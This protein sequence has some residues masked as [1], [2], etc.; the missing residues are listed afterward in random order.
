L[1]IKYPLKGHEGFTGGLDVRNNG[2][3]IQ[4]VY[5]KYASLEIMFHVSTL[6]PHSEVDNQQVEIKRHIG[7]DIVVIIFSETSQ[8][9]SPS[10]ITSEFNHVY[11]VIQP[12]ETQSTPEATYYRIGFASK[13]GVPPFGPI[14]P[15]P[16]IFK[17][18][19]QF[20]EFLLTKL[21][22]AECASLEAPSFGQ[23]LRRTRTVLLNEIARK[24]LKKK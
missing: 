10:S 11:C 20:K 21:I 3:G 1:E 8:P 24:Q 5:T 19:E 22:N 14:I 23:K 12:V 15:Y 16:P 18:D 2:T 17:K 9:F 13:Y 6:L 4:S 7:N